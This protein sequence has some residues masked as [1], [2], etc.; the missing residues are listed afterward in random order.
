MLNSSKTFLE[1]CLASAVEPTTDLKIKRIRQD[2]SVRHV[3]IVVVTNLILAISSKDKCD[4]I[5]WK[6][7][8]FKS[9]MFNIGL[10]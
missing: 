8:S 4:R 6:A 3:M 9:R 1:Q 2:E 5:A 7:S 10:L